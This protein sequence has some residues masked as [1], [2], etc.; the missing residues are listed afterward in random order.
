MRI[1]PDKN[2]PDWILA[3]RFDGDGYMDSGFGLTREY[4]IECLEICEIDASQFSE[5]DIEMI[6]RFII[7]GLTEEWSKH[8]YWN[9]SDYIE[10]AIEKCGETG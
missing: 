10:E 4:V 9:V 7:A 1:R 5:K 6:A 8:F 2:W 3:S